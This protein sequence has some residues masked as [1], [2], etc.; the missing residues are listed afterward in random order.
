MN[1]LPEHYIEKCNKRRL[2]RVFIP[3]QFFIVLLVIFI[4]L[5]M[6]NINENLQTEAN[7][8]TRRILVQETMLYELGLEAMQMEMRAEVIEMLLYDLGVA[9]FSYSLLVAVHENIPSTNIFTRI[10]YENNNIIIHAI[11]THIEYIG[12]H[13]RMLFETNY[14]DNI[15]YGPVRLEDGVYIYS[16]I[17]NI[18]N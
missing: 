1:F 15:W 3:V 18:A 10:Y 2:I 6:Q 5:F 16:L 4:V 17:L 13:R 14:F 9:D 11:T 8:L 7:I 12:L